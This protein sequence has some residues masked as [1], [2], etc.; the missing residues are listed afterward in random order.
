MIVS[1]RENTG[2]THDPLKNK[3]PVREKASFT[4]GTLKMN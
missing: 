2:F 1:V 3:C 4:H